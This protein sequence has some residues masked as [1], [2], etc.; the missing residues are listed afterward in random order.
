VNL[1]Q[2]SVQLLARGDFGQQRNSAGAWY[3]PNIGLFLLVLARQGQKP[4]ARR[5]KIAR[6]R[7]RLDLAR[8][9]HEDA[10]R[11]AKTLVGKA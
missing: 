9:E 2:P 7:E 3:G 10:Q 8:A 4:A 6:A 11:L 1:G 5:D